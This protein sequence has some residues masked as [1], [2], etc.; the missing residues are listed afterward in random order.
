[1]RTLVRSLRDT[2][3]DRLGGEEGVGAGSARQSLGAGSTALIAADDFGVGR[4]DVAGQGL[5]GQGG[6][7]GVGGG[8]MSRS[9]RDAA[10]GKQELRALKPLIS[11]NEWMKLSSAK[12]RKKMRKIASR[13]DKNERLSA[14][15]LKEANEEE[16]K[17]DAPAL[18][19]VCLICL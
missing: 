14:R 7:G 1:L 12:Q 9:L 15:L 6:G 3:A 2:A 16:S 13:Q 10:T 5:A 11:L 17:M 18:R 19:H 4:R 8:G